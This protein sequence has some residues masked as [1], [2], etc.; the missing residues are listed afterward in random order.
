MISCD[1]TTDR[2]NDRQRRR[3]LQDMKCQICN[4]MVK[5]PAESWGKVKAVNK[6]N[7]EKSDWN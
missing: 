4:E 3:R 7:D 5:I 2:M 1:T 6:Y